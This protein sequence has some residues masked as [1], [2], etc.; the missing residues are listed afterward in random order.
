MLVK[1]TGRGVAGRAKRC[2]FASDGIAPIV[3]LDQKMFL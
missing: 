2:Y 1:D 3:F